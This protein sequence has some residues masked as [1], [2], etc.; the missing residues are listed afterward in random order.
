M[1]SDQR[2]INIRWTLALLLLI[3]L[4]STV[5]WTFEEIHLFGFLHDES[6][7]TKL[8]YSSEGSFQ[9]KWI[10]LI[11]CFFIHYNLSHLLQNLSVMGWFGFLVEKNVGKV[12]FSLIIFIPHIISVFIVGLFS[13]GNHVFLGS[14]LGCVSLFVYYTV[15]NKKWGGLVIGGTVICLYPLLFLDDVF[16]F[17][18]H[19]IAGLIS[20]MLYFI[21]RNKTK[22][23]SHVD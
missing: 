10:R 9:E 4:F 18:L 1:L 22:V 5:T 6:L 15:V 23:T 2:F 16:S 11:S 19:S 13:N 17:Y 8:S 3:S 7:L 14:S 20:G 12:Y 21:G